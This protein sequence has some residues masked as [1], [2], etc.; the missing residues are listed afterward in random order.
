MRNAKYLA[1]KTNTASALDRLR[2]EMYSQENGGRDF[3]SK[4]AFIVTDGK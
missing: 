1:G 4:V 2:T 3:A